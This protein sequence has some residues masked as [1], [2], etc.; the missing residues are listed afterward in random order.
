M[1]SSPETDIDYFDNFWKFS[2]NVERFV[3]V[4]TK[5]FAQT[6]IFIIIKLSKKSEE[7]FF[8]YR[9]QVN[10]SSGKHESLADN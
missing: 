4:G 6:G 3:R 10:L 8:N 7:G 1:Y 9:Q 5:T 2:S